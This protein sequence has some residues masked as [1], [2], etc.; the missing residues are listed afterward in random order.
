M[1]WEKFNLSQNCLESSRL[2]NNRDAEDIAR[3]ASSNLIAHAAEN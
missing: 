2:V 3:P 1:K